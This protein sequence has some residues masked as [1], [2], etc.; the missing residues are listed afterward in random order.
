MAYNSYGAG[1]TENIADSGTGINTSEYYNRNL[2]ENAREKLKIK[3]T[4]NN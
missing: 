3:Y 2:L 4:N 1:R